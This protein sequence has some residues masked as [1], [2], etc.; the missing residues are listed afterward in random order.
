[1][2]REARIQRLRDNGYPMIHLFGNWYWG[3]NYSK[4]YKKFSL[5]GL[6]H[7]KEPAIKIED[8]PVKPTGEYR[9]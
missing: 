7:Y 3:R 6:F 9:I 8:T 1:M 5:W 4:N 2:E